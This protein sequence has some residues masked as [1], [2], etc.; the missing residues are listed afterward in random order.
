MKIGRLSTGSI[1]FVYFM[2]GAIFMIMIPA[3][4]FTEVEGWSAL[5][6]MYFIIISLTQGSK[7]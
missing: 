3:K 6:A 4:I 7:Q 1:A 2:L 5:D